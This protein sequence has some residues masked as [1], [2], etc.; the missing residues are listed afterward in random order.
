MKMNDAPVIMVTTH[1]QSTSISDARY[2]LKGLSI[3]LASLRDFRDDC[4]WEE[5]EPVHCWNGE[6][7]FSVIWLPTEGETPVLMPDFVKVENGSLL[8]SLARYNNTLAI[9]TQCVDDSLWINGLGPR[10]LCWDESSSPRDMGLQLLQ[11]LKKPL[12]KPAQ[13]TRG[14]C[15]R[16]IVS[17]VERVA[18]VKRKHFSEWKTAAD[19]GR[20]LKAG[21]LQ[22]KA[23]QKDS[24]GVFVFAAW[25]ILVSA[26]SCHTREN[27]P[28]AYL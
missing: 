19:M 3:A 18:H 6:T 25:C 21:H 5:E 22:K 12:V 4:D 27:V 8:D 26:F 17:L 14:D 7:D 13:L 2:I 20:D 11:L 9:V 23:S 28:E 15:L 10:V 1:G 16:R 24:S